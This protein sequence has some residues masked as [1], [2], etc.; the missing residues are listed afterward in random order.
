MQ[1]LHKHTLYIS[2]T[3]RSL[4]FYTNKLGMKLINSFKEENKE[5]YQL[6]FDDSKESKT[7]YM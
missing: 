3:K 5:F 2:N 1:Y 7:I 6:S 4:E